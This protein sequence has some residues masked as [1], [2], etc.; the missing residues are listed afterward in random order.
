PHDAVRDAFAHWLVLELLPAEQVFLDQHLRAVGEP[1]AD[2]RAQLRLVRAQARAQAAE[3][4][5]DAHHDRVADL[6]RERK[7]FFQRAGGAA[8]RI[9]DADFRELRAKERSVFRGFD[10]GYR[11]AEDFDVEFLEYFFFVQSKATIQ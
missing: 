4:V 2:A 8:A 9:G 5:G 3:R 7:G 11:G 1:V 6:A 10:C